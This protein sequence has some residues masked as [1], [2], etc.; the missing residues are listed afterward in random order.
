MSRR[1]ETAFLADCLKHMPEQPKQVQRAVNTAVAGLKRIAN[2]EEW[3]EDE[4]MATLAACAAARGDDAGRAATLAVYAAARAADAAAWAAAD[5]AA[6]AA[7]G[8]EQASHLAAKA[9]PDLAKERA[10]QAKVREKLGLNT[11]QEAD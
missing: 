5:T 2:G 7:Y 3:P 6:C 1:K 11:K 10:R 4:V 8:A 9:H